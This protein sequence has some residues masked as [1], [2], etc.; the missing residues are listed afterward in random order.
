MDKTGKHFAE[1]EI[2]HYLNDSLPPKQRNALERHL[3]TCR[4]CFVLY[5]EIREL[6]YLARLGQSASAELRRNVKEIAR[7]ATG[8]LL[9]VRFKVL[10]DK[11]IMMTGDS[12]SLEFQAL[13]TN[14]AY[15]GKSERGPVSFTHK[16]GKRTVTLT[17]SPVAGQKSFKISIEL[18]KPEKLGAQLVLDTQVIETIEDLRS[19]SGFLSVLDRGKDFDLVIQKSGKEVFTI[20]LAID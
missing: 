17:L 16:I 20:N 7:E 6:D 2:R 1:Q 12:E 11:F 5:M 19:Q 3:E 15:R 18:A 14:L 9:R 8:K 13:R 4:S 10:K